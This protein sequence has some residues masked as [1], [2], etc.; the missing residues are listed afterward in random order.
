MR[1]GYYG[2]GP[3]SL[4]GYQHRRLLRRRIRLPWAARNG[5][6]Q[7][8]S[9]AKPRADDIARLAEQSEEEAHFLV[10]CFR[11]GALS[12]CSVT[13]TAITGPRFRT[14]F[15]TVFGALCPRTVTR[16][17]SP[18][19]IRP[20]GDPSPP[21]PPTLRTRRA[22]CARRQAL[23]CSQQPFAPARTPRHRES[24][25]HEPGGARGDL[26]RNDSRASRAGWASPSSRSAAGVPAAVGQV[27]L[28]CDK[29]TEP[30]FGT[31]RFRT[32]MIYRLTL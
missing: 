13:S 12:V 10:D 32:R 27:Q 30:T 2:A 28:G 20:P 22:V 16:R 26:V 15:P 25:Q 9:S 24:R 11:S 23:E 3:R 17:A 7:R 19:P 6:L 31:S 4:S 18:S 29:P 5:E 1:A 14:T 21:R 8:L